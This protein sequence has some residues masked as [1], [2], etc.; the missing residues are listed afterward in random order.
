M[1]CKN[2]MLLGAAVLLAGVASAQAASVTYLG[3]E[4]N[5]KFLFQNETWEN[6]ARFMWR[7]TGPGYAKAYDADNNN[8]YGS[9]GY[10]LYNSDRFGNENTITT[11]SA[12]GDAKVATDITPYISQISVTQGV[13]RVDAVQGGGDTLE[14][15]LNPGTTVNFGSMMRNWEDNLVPAGGVGDFLDISVGSAKTFTVGFVAGRGDHQKPAGIVLGGVTAMGTPAINNYDI[16]DWYFF[17]VTT[18]GPEVLKLQ[19]VRGVDG[20]GDP[21]GQSGIDAIVFDSAVPEPAS[22]AMLVLGCTALLYRR[23][24]GMTA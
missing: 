8:V 2:Q 12:P 1:F 20:D 15:P 21:V 19:L 18:T 4:I 17:S 5:T 16:P 9:D 3:S 10:I 14:H 13:G 7:T 6:G 23:R 11:G 24:T 22:M